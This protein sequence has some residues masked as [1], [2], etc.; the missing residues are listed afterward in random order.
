[1]HFF[2]K[3]RYIFYAVVKLFNTYNE[4]NII[5]IILAP[6]IYLE[7]IFI[8]LM[9]ILFDIN[10]SN[11]FLEIRLIESTIFIEQVANA[12]KININL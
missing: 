11:L 3:Q 4:N 12:K 5:I 2:L 7:N 6:L 10:L 8:L 1:M 9:Q